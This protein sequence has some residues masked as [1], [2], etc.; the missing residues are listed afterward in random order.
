MPRDKTIGGR[1][2]KS[3]NATTTPSKKTKKNAN[4]AAVI[5]QEMMESSGGVVG[6]ESDDFEHLKFEEVDD[7]DA[8]AM[9]AGQLDWANG[10]ASQGFLDD[11]PFGVFYPQ[12][13]GED[14]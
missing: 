14:A 9:A 5:K 10:N 4:A 12:V 1:I 11:A 2:G 3:V 7:D 6:A 13:G 8:D